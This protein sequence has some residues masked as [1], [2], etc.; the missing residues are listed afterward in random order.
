[1]GYDG[2]KGGEAIIA[3]GGTIIAQDEKSSVVWGMPGAVAS[4]G[5]CTAVLPLNELASFVAGY[6]E[7]GV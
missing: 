7:K 6:I 1:M 5:Y 2:L 4:A 3:S